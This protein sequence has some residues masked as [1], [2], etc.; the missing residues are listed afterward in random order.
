MHSKW[1]IWDFFASYDRN[2]LN[3]FQGT[4]AL[5][6]FDPICLKLMKDFLLK[7]ADQTIYFKAASEVT[8]GW[9]EEEFQTLSLFGTSESFFIHQA[10]D[11]NAE[12][13]ELIMNL[14]V[15]GRYLILSFESEGTSWKKLVKDGRVSTLTVESPRFWELHKLLDFVCSHVRLPLSYEAKAWMLDALENNL[16]T[17]YNSCCLIKLNFPESR[18]VSLTQVK[19]LLTMEKLDQF[20]M[21]SLFARKKFQPFFERI[22]SL[23]GD[24]EKMRS[25]FNFLQS[26]LVKM[27]DPSYLAAKPRLTQYDK[28]IQSSSK[29]WSTADLVARIEA[30]NRWELMCK[31]KDSFLWHELRDAHL[32]SLNPKN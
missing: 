9:I 20:E 31:R 18:E 22:V 10:Q 12:M 26:H 29:L 7:N 24:F 25:L 32:Q 28:D 30:C 5:N 3:S 11:L 27:T 19:E 2:F 16:A 4:L 6:S 21:A 8:K 14:E 1:Q 17:F 15:T 13:I 23:Q